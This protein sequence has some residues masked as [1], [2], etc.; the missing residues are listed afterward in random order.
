MRPISQ[1]WQEVIPRGEQ[2]EGRNERAGAPEDVG[3]GLDPRR[4]VL[5]VRLV[6]P[7]VD[8]HQD[9]VKCCGQRGV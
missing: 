8:G 7:V 6:G 2:G 1:P 3:H 5:Q 9:D 4:R